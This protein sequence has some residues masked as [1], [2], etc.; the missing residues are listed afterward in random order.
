[1][2]LEHDDDGKSNRSFSINMIPWEP[3]FPAFFGVISPTFLGPKTCIFQSFG[4]QRTSTLQSGVKFQLP[5]LCFGGVLGLK[6]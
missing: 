3:T 4:V 5:G 2:N 1:M 6:F